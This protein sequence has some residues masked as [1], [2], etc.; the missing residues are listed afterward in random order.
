MLDNAPCHSN[1]EDVLKAEEFA[2]A[3][4][5]QLGLYSPMLNPIANV[6]STFKAA[7]KKHLALQRQAIINTPPGTTQVAHRK[8]FLIQA[9]DLLLE[10]VVTSELCV[11]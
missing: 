1:A 7:I 6:L 2:G 9:A 10:E 5:L 4:M 8:S 11:K 3:S